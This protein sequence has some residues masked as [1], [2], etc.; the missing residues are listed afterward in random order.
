MSRKPITLFVADTICHDIGN[1]PVH[2]AGGIL[3]LLQDLCAD[4]AYAK[5]ALDPLPG[6][7][8]A[9]SLPMGKG[10][11]TRIL[12]KPD[13][14]EFLV[15]HVVPGHQPFAGVFHESTVRP[16]SMAFH[17]NA[18]TLAITSQACEDIQRH[19]PRWAVK[20]INLMVRFYEDPASESLDHKSLHNSDDFY[21]IRLDGSNRG[22]TLKP[23]FPKPVELIH[24][25]PHDSARRWIKG[26]KAT[27]LTVL[28]TIQMHHG[29]FRP[30]KA[31]QRRITARAAHRELQLE[32]STLRKLGIPDSLFKTVRSLGS[33]EDL[34]RVREL[35]SEQAI[36]AING[37]MAKQTVGTIRRNWLAL[38]P[39]ETDVSRTLGTDQDQASSRYSFE[40]FLASPD[41]ES[42]ER[43]QIMANKQGTSRAEENKTLKN[44]KAADLLKSGTEPIPHTIERL[45]GQIHLLKL[46]CRELEKLAALTAECRKNTDF[47]PCME[48]VCHTVS[49][50]AVDKAGKALFEKTK[51][52]GDMDLGLALEIFEAAA[53]LNGMDPKKAK[54]V[55]TALTRFS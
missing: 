46:P 29:S 44:L 4:P 16:R 28:G 17:P 55:S 47:G 54:I 15:T 14:R 31:L 3:K 7:P 38:H 30:A 45:G 20:A 37:R 39:Q 36:H 18:P 32:D 41:I 42:K 33:P 43:G 48:L 23:A 52:V 34:A 50:C 24:V 35:F 49:V 19:S 1:L 53:E 25:G 10:W 27:A 40:A 22:V 8:R 2:V 26:R 11:T 13:S 9:Y 6:S 51:Q 12:T 21:S 5:A